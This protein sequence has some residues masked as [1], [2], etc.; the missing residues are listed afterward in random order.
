MLD[1]FFWYVIVVFA[2]GAVGGLVAHRLIAVRDGQRG[3]Y[4]PKFGQD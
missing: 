3:R 4:F 1:F 2:I